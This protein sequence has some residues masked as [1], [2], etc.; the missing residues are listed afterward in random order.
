MC[1]GNNVN[2]TTIHFDRAVFTPVSH[3]P[4]DLF[5]SGFDVLIVDPVNC[6]DGFTR[7][8]RAHVN[9]A[10]LAGTLKV[11]E[12]TGICRCGCDRFRVGNVL[13]KVIRRPSEKFESSKNLLIYGIVNHGFVN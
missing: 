5:Q 10:Y 9:A 3:E 2:C 11:S 1:S 4:I 8:G 6:V 7:T 12:N 13:H